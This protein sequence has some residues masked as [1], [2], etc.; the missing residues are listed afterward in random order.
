MKRRLSGGPS[1]AAAGRARLEEGAA[2]HRHGDAEAQPLSGAHLGE[3]GLYLHRLHDRHARP[4]PP[5]A[6]HLLVAHG[7]PVLRQLLCDRVRDEFFSEPKSAL[8]DQPSRAC[9]GTS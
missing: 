4:M 9:E 8:D 1:L 3:D 2:V 7:R 6:S 5:G